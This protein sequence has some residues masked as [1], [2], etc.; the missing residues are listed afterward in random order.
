MDFGKTPSVCSTYAA[1]QRLAEQSNLDI[2]FATHD[3]I[4]T[5]LPDV[6][7]VHILYG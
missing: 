4:A 6:A 5:S 7:K 3:N 2:A 1:V